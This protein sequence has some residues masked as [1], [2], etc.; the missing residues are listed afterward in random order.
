MIVAP[1]AGRQTF[2]FQ[3]RIVLRN[4]AP[5]LGN[6]TAVMKNSAGFTVFTDRFFD[7][8]R[9]ALVHQ[10]GLFHSRIHVARIFSALKNLVPAGC[11][12]TRLNRYNIQKN[13]ARIIFLHNF[14]YLFFEQVHV[15]GV[16]TQYVKIRFS[17]KIRS[18][19]QRFVRS[20]KQ[21]FRVPHRFFFV[22]A[23]GYIYGSAYADFFT[24][25]QLSLQQ[26]EF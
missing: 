24:C 20:A 16:K 9:I 26:I 18:P 2:K 10:L 17:G 1:A 22:Q 19:T 14:F 5:P 8:L 4:V 7:P 13:T 21:P 12:I 25:V 11:T 15:A 23:G 6:M 3:M